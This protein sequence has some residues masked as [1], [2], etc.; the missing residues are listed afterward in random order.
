[1][2]SPKSKRKRDVVVKIVED[3][4]LSVACVRTLI[5]TQEYL[6]FTVAGWKVSC[7]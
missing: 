1:M 6:I 2:L 4:I 7:L 5:G 3:V